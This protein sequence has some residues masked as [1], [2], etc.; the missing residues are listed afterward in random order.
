MAVRDSDSALPRL[1]DL[2]TVA[3]LV[4]GVAAAQLTQIVAGCAER[5]HVKGSI[6]R[7]RRCDTED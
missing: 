2:S 5:Q 3:A 4:S 7:I 1:I 6:L